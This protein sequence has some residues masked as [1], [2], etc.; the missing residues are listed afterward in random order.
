M[1]KAS[2]RLLAVR[3]VFDRP[4]SMTCTLIRGV[5]KAGKVTIRPLE[6][7]IERLTARIRTVKLVVLFADNVLNGNKTLKPERLAQGRE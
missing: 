5:Q 1:K 7:T 6:L 3:Q 4:A 2:S